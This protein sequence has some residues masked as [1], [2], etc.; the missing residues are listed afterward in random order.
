MAARSA[1]AFTGREGRALQTKAQD[2]KRRQQLEHKLAVLQLK[3][4]KDE[5]LVPDS[6]DYQRGRRLLQRE[7]ISST[8]QEIEALVSA[9]QAA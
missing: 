9:L 1:T 3:L 5:P 4:H 6:A 2:P 7:E 8:Q